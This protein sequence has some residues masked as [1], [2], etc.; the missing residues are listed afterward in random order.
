MA[1]RLGL[2]LDWLDIGLH[3]WDNISQGFLDVP[4][5]DITPFIPPDE[6]SGPQRPGVRHGAVAL[7]SR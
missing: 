4:V 5:G 3:C 2:L 1:A 6:A 7:C